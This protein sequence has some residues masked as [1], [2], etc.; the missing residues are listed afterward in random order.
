MMQMLT[1][2][3]VNPEQDPNHV[4]NP[5]QDDPAVILNS[6]AAVLALGWQAGDN[7]E[8]QVNDQV[9]PDADAN[10]FLDLEN[11]A[12]AADGQ[13]AS[14]EQ[15]SSKWSSLKTPIAVLVAVGILFVIVYCA[16]AHDTAEHSSSGNEPTHYGPF[17][18]AG[19]STRL[20]NRL[21]ADIPTTSLTTSRS[22]A[23]TSTEPNSSPQEGWTRRAKWWTAGGVGTALASFI[24][25]IGASSNL[26]KLTDSY[27][28]VIEEAWQGSAEDV[29][30]V[31][32][33][34]NDELVKDI[35]QAAKANDSAIH[36]DELA[37]G[38]E[39]ATESV[40]EEENTFFLDLEDK[41]AVTDAIKSNLRPKLS[42]VDYYDDDKLDNL[43]DGIYNHLVETQKEDANDPAPQSWSKTGELE[44][45]E[46]DENDLSESF[47]ESNDG[48]VAGLVICIML[49]MALITV[50]LFGFCNRILCWEGTKEG[51]FC[52]K[53]CPCQK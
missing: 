19:Y 4:P 5:V 53:Q 40:A 36:T 3:L 30:K 24:G 39:Q 42:G 22:S 34:S 47:V 44:W 46:L 28:D 20:D 23:T 6:D 27:K 49:F 8:K 25:I 13:D 43:A 52:C 14:S 32:L 50:S 35:M 17:L 12:A 41:D 1:K 21:P 9:S 7:A 10:P 26:E 38:T 18:P 33:E 45:I 16:T 11:N 29:H 31:L 51:L 15:A 37:E 48:A 2:Y